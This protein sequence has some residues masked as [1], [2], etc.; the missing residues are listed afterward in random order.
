MDAPGHKYDNRRASETG[1]PLRFPAEIRQMTKYTE[2]YII[3]DTVPPIRVAYPPI[4]LRQPEFFAP[5]YGRPKLTTF[6]D[7]EAAFNEKR[8]KQISEANEGAAG[9]GGGGPDAGGSGAKRGEAKGG[10]EAK[11]GGDGEANLSQVAGGQSSGSGPRGRKDKPAARE[12]RDEA[13]KRQP[14]KQGALWVGVDKA[15]RD[16]ARGAVDE[17]GARARVIKKTI[18][19]DRDADVRQDDLV[20][21]RG[22]EEGS[23]EHVDAMFFD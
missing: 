1:R 6:E 5:V 16:G 9:E 20:L 15:I 8:A 14:G 7:A 4:A 12:R 21:N 19:P 18:P 2:A 23:H 13:A 3:T 11:D 17:A 10:G 22:Y